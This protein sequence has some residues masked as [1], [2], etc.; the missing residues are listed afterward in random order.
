MRTK[1]LCLVALGL[2]VGWLSPCFGQ[3][4]ID[5][6][7]SGLLP[8]EYYESAAQQIKVG[9]TSEDQ[10]VKLL[11]N[12]SHSIQGGQDKQVGYGPLPKSQG[13]AARYAIEITLNSGKV[14]KVTTNIPK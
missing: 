5:T 12:P 14:S 1:W 8:S 3:F 6:M 10:V 11:G 9:E 4:E 7:K 13:E 2:V